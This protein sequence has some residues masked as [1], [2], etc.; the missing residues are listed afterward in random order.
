MTIT[1]HDLGTDKKGSV[2][3]VLIRDPMVGKTGFFYFL[4]FLPNLS[5]ANS[6]KN[7]YAPTEA[8]YV[9]PKSITKAY[10]N[11]IQVSGKYEDRGLGSLLINFIEKWERERGV[12]EIYGDLSRKDEDHF[13]K[14]Q[15]FY[16]KHGWTFELFDKKTI[17]ERTMI[18][19]KVYK[20]LE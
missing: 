16:E 6:V 13:D 7:N 1:I 14:L 2:W 18:L 19:G 11:D 4:P 9:H 12:T 10:L 15:H 8:A 3:K 17:T 20:E 5:S